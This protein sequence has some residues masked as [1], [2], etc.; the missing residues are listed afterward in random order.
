MHFVDITYHHYI[1]ASLH[2]GR[3]F[4][5]TI[6]CKGSYLYRFCTS[7]TRNNIYLI[8]DS[9]Q[10][11]HSQICWVLLEDENDLFVTWP[12]V[13]SDNIW[14]IITPFIHKVFKFIIILYNGSTETTNESLVANCLR[15]NA[16]LSTN[17]IQFFVLS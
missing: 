4:N 17:T 7:V 13:S 1:R 5:K 12:E 16:S 11:I 14:Q 10:G 2:L 3:S 8:R 6:N 9:L 15:C